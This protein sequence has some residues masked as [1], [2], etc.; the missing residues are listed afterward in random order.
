M[1]TFLCK[2]VGFLVPTNRACVNRRAIRAG[3]AHIAW[4]AMLIVLAGAGGAQAQSNWINTTTSAAQAWGTA[5]NWSPSGV[6]SG[7]GVVV[8]FTANIGAS[9]TVTLGSARTIGTLNLGLSG[10][11]NRYNFS[12]TANGLTFR[13]NAGDTLGTATININNNSDANDGHAV[14]GTVN[15]QIANLVINNNSVDGRLNFQRTFND[16]DSDT[17]R[18]PTVTLNAVAGSNVLQFQIQS[19]DTTSRNQ[20]GKLVVNQNAIFRNSN[21]NAVS[22]TV[23]DRALGTA[24]TSYL[25]DAITLNGGVLQGADG[26]LIYNVSANRGVTLGSL[27]GTLERSWSVDSIITGAGGL[28]KTGGGTTTFKAANTYAGQTVIT[29]GTLALGPAGSIASSLGIFLSGTTTG[30]NLSAA[31]GGGITIGSGKGVGGLGTITGNLSLGSGAGLVLSSSAL[32]AR[33]P[34]SVTGTVS[35]PNAFGVASLFG[36]TGQPFDFSLIQD[37]TYPLINNGSSFANISNFGAGNAANIG[38]G[39]TAY[40]TE[41]S[42]NLIIVPEP[43]TGFAIATALAAVACWRRAR[44]RT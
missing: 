16:G 14:Q 21:P 8:N 40:F 3:G 27:G 41:G 6:P 11:A 1:N 9:Q 10:N 19:G 7:A 15:L 18:S 25:A 24:L 13:A 44:R 37:G 31:S 32:L 17:S 2:H 38:G 42:L 5:G 33:V 4:M 23:D 22:G 20:W 39:R 34:L 43:A 35:L 36:T 26:N 30:L 28:T 29:G 12:N